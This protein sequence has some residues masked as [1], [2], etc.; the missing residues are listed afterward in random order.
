MNK[1]FEREVFIDSV[2]RVRSLRIIFVLVFICVFFGVWKS[3][4]LLWIELLG[5]LKWQVIGLE[6]SVSSFSTSRRCSRKQSTTFSLFSNVDFCPWCTGCAVGDFSGDE[7]KSINDVDGS[8]T[9]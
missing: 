6:A 8:F 1:L 9:S 4:R 7:C 5:N 3:R 2:L